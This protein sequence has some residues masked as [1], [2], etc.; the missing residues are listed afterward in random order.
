MSDPF[1][2]MHT[3]LFA[4]IGTEAVLRGADPCKVSVS[5]GVAI[6]GEY[7]EVGSYRTVV[8]VMYAGVDKPKKGDAL[9]AGTDSYV[10]DAELSDDGYTAKWI[11]R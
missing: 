8:E 4:A 10:M 9:T 3:R 6:A 2:R 11:V 7:G 5:R 1:A